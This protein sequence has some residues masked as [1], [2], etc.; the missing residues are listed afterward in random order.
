M[1]KLV[2][3]WITTSIHVVLACPTLLLMVVKNSP[4]LSVNQLAQYLVA[5]HTK[6]LSIIREN[7]RPSAFKVAYYGDASTAIREF[8][9]GG[10]SDESILSAKADELRHQAER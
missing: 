6:R 1:T 10:L 5:S 2:I 7:K 8:F 9:E 4:Q 3:N